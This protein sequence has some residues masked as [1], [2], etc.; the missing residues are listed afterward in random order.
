M[1]SVAQNRILR[2]KPLQDDATVAA[3]AKSGRL[4]LGRSYEFP[5]SQDFATYTLTARL[6]K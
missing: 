6:P 2:A 1:N 5:L 4:E 3:A